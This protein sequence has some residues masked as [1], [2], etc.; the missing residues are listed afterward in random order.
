VAQPLEPASTSSPARR[1]IKVDGDVISDAFTHGN[2][3]HP[4]DPLV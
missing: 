4:N 2:S 3:G 1:R